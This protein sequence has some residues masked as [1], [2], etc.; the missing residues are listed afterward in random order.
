MADSQP[1][2]PGSQFAYTCN[3]CMSCCH[4]AHI[5]LDP[6]EI[7]RLARNQQLTTT[8]FIARFLTEGGIV[9]RNRDDTSCVMLGADGCTVYPDRPAICRTYPLKRIRTQD[10]EVFLKYSLP[11]TSKG[12]FGR[13]GTASDFL[14]AHDVDQLFAAKDRYFDLAARIATVLAEA[15]KR[16]PHLFATIRELIDARCEVN[17]FKL[18]RSP[19]CR[20]PGKVPYLID[21]DRVVSDY[22]REHRIEFPETLDEKIALHT[23]AIEERLEIIS[24]HSA[25]NSDENDDLI[26]MAEFAGALGAATEFR[27]LLA[28][29]DGVFGGG[30]SKVTRG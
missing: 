4:D 9:L 29:V 7:A 6:Y 16:K 5:A 11:P 27:V 14:K 25:G 3:R 13:D 20:Q 18:R 12:V 8:N 19:N 28:F 1:L 26:E 24:A 10:G 15:V 30:E 22:C 2:T 21:V 23:R 17:G